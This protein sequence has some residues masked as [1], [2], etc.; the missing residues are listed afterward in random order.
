MRKSE[1]AFTVV[2]LT[3]FLFFF[4]LN[5]VRIYTDG[6]AHSVHLQN[7]TYSSIHLC[8]ILCVLLSSSCSLSTA[9][10]LIQTVRSLAWCCG[11]I[12]CWWSGE[13][14]TDCKLI[15]I[16][17]WFKSVNVYC[18]HVLNMHWHHF[19]EM[20]SVDCI[21][22]HTSFQSVDSHHPTFTAFFLR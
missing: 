18:L 21:L 12:S 10:L 19:L 1:V 17:I 22:S 6:Y 20:M 13:V 11:K 4:F 5:C 9:V 2:T 15:G 16:C 8:L 3:F 7:I 14:D